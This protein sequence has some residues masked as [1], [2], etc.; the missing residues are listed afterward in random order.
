MYYFTGAKHKENI[1]CDHM[2][3]KPQTV[4]PEPVAFHSFY[5]RMKR[6][7][8]THVWY[9]QFKMNFLSLSL[10]EY[11]FLSD[12]AINYV[13]INPIIHAKNYI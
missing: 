2:L 5:W 10:S 4:A 8:I 6:F 3:K 1:C 12:R 7:L 13:C 11:K 9:E